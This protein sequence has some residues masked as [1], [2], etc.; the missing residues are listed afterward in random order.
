MTNNFDDFVN[1]NKK[2]SKV[3]NKI[4]NMLDRYNRLPFNYQSKIG[5]DTLIQKAFPKI[6]I[7]I[8]GT[9]IT[10]SDKERKTK[11]SRIDYLESKTNSQIFK[12][13]V[14]NCIQNPVMLIREIF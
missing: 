12:S 6:L 10:H 9:T 1:V 7:N 2:D 4:N 11:I 3:R 5:Y 13:P 8:M 14:T